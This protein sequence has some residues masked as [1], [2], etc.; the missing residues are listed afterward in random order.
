[1][2]QETCAIESVPQRL[3]P[4]I[5]IDVVTVLDISIGTNWF[6]IP[7][8]DKKPIAGGQY[9][10]VVVLW[11]GTGSMISLPCCSWLRNRWQW[12]S[13][14]CGEMTSASVIERFGML[15]AV[16]AV[17]LDVSSPSRMRLSYTF[18]YEK[19]VNVFYMFPRWYQIDK[20]IFYHD[21]DSGG[22]SCCA[23][24]LVSLLSIVRV[25]SSVWV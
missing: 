17:I 6:T 12:V 14:S 8:V 19:C 16:V 1:M 2:S 22:G 9:V 11:C 20:L 18:N 7:F 24:V 4:L 15:V 13:A 3:L 21:D 5:D 10:V 23:M 25:S